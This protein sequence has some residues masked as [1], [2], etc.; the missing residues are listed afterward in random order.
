MSTP[1]GRVKDKVKRRFQQ[2]FPEC[3]RFMPVQNGM[4]TPCLDMLFCV[5][6][7]FIAIETK[8]PPKPGHKAPEP[9][10]RQWTTMAE[11]AKAG[12]L[13]YLVYDD[14][15]LDLAM[16]NIWLHLEFRERKAA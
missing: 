15:T 6:G 11:I 13:A 10:P 16:A 5:H 7:L 12:G 8:A 1:E 3:Y 4:G 9:T 2:H 14:A